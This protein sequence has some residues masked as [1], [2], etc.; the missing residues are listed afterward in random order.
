M[1][2]KNDDDHTALPPRGGPVDGAESSELDDAVTADVAE[3]ADGAIRD[4][5]KSGDLTADGREIENAAPPQES[6]DDEVLEPGYLLGD[7]Y[8]IVSLVYSGGMGH[9]YKAID[10]RRLSAG[11]DQVPVAIKMMRRSLTPRLDERL[12]LEREAATAQHLSH[13]NIISVYDFDEHDGQFYLVM[14]WLDGESVKDLLR[15]TSGRRL[16]P[17]FAWRIIHGIAAGVQHAHSNGVVHA[18]INPSNIF[19]TDTQEIRLLD[20]GVARFCSTSDEA[21]GD[22]SVW[23]TRAY[24]SPEVL[25]GSTPVIED[26]IFSLGCVAYR[27]LSG[28]HPFDGVSSNEAEEASLTVQRV[29]GLDEADWENLRGALAFARSDRPNNAEAFLHVSPVSVGREPPGRLRR[30]ATSEWLLIM[31]AAAIA[32]VAVVWALSEGRSR[33]AP[34]L[35]V[36]TIPAEDEPTVSDEAPVAPSGVD[37]LLG[38]AVQAMDEERF[39][40]PEDNN[41]RAL[42]RIVLTLEPANS[43]A[44][45]GLREISDVYVQ[46]ADAALRAGEPEQA[47]DALAIALDTDPDN[48]AIRMVNELVLAQGDRQLSDARLAAAEGDADRASQLLAEAERYAHIDENAIAAVR[49]LITANARE[50][51]FLGR[52][53]EA[54]AHLAAGRLTAPDGN[55]AQATLLGLTQRYGSEARLLATMERLGGRLLTRAAFETAADRFPEATQLL[56]AVDLLGVLAPEV[57]AA[58]TA[59]QRAID[60]NAS[61]SIAAS[62]APT[63]ATDGE[64]GATPPLDAGLVAV[65]AA[66]DTAPATSA[67]AES[68]ASALA[69][70]GSRGASPQTATSGETASLPTP[71]NDSPGPAPASATKV[72]DA[73]AKSPSQLL[74]ELAIERYVAPKFPPR[75]ELKGQTGYVDLRFSVFP[76]GSTGDIEILEARPGTVFVA[77][78]EN[79][80]RQ[81]RFASRDEVYTARLRLS[82]DLPPP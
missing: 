55:N 70:G 45:T 41:A 54:E 69:G 56:D 51:Q 71:A 57:A 34:L 53:A 75:A 24:A 22:S 20:F 7:R 48:P 76:D 33:D 72:T 9:V 73:P 15:R 27:L 67:T 4:Y 59:L 31:P 58:R 49:D 25:S 5:G 37:L 36:E 6:T 82:F 21:S 11:V 43:V 28:T 12:A 18:D 81:W 74:S 40:S 42:Y 38:S 77:S 46:R 16:A 32:I 78:A 60:I 52:L 19:I 65:P 66:I 3:N 63:L 26:D 30:G 10:S 35:I 17:E 13:P 68:D 44:L 14:E 1:A 80:V 2:Q 8:E 23:A 79:A 29:A 39:I 50:R 47:A 61:E 62:A 64:P